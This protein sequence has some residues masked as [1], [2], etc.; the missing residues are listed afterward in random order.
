MIPIIL[1]SNSLKQTNSFIKDFVKKSKISGNYIFE[2]RPL[3][4]EFSIEQI[5]EVKKSI[6][7]NFS[8]LHL[9]ILFDFDTASFEAQNAFL[10]TLEEHQQTIQFM[11][12]VRNPHKLTDT[13]L[14]RSKV[15]NL[16]ETDKFL[17]DREL[18]SVLEQFLKSLDLKILSHSKL[19]VKK[20]DKPSDLF[21]NFTLFFRQRLSVD[22]ETTKI[23]KEILSTSYLVENN[24]VDPQ[25]GIDH[26]FLYIRKIYQQG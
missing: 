16:T 9:Y 15:L 22:P 23:L 21:R 5:R 10:K 7:Y 26:I 2:I 3:T 19:Q 25:A 24:H 13:V 4:K 20:A 6:I 12:V 1:I 17:L 11:M 18:G 14:S 8:A